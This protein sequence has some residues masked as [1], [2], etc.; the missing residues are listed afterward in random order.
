MSRTDRNS[1][2]L[3]SIWHRTS[4]GERLKRT[5]VR[6]C[7][8]SCFRMSLVPA[9]VLLD[10]SSFIQFPPCL[11]QIQVEL[12]TVV[13]EPVRARLL[14]FGKSHEVLW[15]PLGF[16]ASWQRRLGP[17]PATISQL[18][19]PASLEQIKWAQWFFNQIT[20]APNRLTFLTQVLFPLSSSP[21]LLSPQPERERVE[22]HKL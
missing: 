11:L 6:L 18:H 19:A 7:E 3:V 14:I 20:H 8:I 22:V 2:P 21:V 16:S 1:K 4:E 10:E 17:C 12:G 15:L 9:V 5:G 13:T